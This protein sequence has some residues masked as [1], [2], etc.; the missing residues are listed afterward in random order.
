M[1]SILAQTATETSVPVTS[2]IALLIF[3]IAFLLLL[4]LR[5][6]LQAFLALLVVSV[7]VSIGATFINPDQAAGLTE[8]GQTIVESMQ[9]ALGFIATI[10]GI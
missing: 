9:T 3:G 5:F 10:I 8:I 1:F 7:V 6:K 2:L 4:I